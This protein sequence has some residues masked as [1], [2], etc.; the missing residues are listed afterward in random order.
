MA[1]FAINEA[2]ENDDQ[3][4][5]LKDLIKAEWKTDP[6][7]AEHLCRSLEGKLEC[8]PLVCSEQFEDRSDFSLLR[9]LE[10]QDSSIVKDGEAFTTYA[11]S[12]SGQS[13]SSASSTIPD[14]G[15]A[16]SSS[17]KGPARGPTG[18]NLGNGIYKSH[19]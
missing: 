8:A 18:A 4:S 6:D 7:V 19:V 17:S 13:S 14:N 5:K 11:P 2:K 15:G 12:S 3:C 9:H 1:D 10:L 16:I